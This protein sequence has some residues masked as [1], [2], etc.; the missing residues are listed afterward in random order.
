MK[1]RGLCRLGVFLPAFLLTVLGSS[2]VACADVITPGEALY[3]MW[4]RNWPAIIGLVA[5]V[6][7]LTA[8]LIILFRR[9]S[10]S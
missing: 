4:K 6:V 1:K 8:I 9:K 10:K 7:I 3:R 5:G 2:L